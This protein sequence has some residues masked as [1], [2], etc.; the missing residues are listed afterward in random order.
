MGP[1]PNTRTVSPALTSARATSCVATESGSM[2]A[3]SSSASDAGT[4]RSRSTGTF[5]VLA[6]AARQIDAEH[7]E[8]VAKIVGADATRAA[9]AAEKNRLDH[10]A[11]AFGEAG[12]GG[13]LRDV[14]E[15]L[16][17]DDAVLR[18]T[19]IEMPLEDVQV[20]AA[21]AHAPHAEQ[22]FAGR[23]ALASAASRFQRSD[24]RDRTTRACACLLGVAWLFRTSLPGPRSRVVV[25]LTI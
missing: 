6:H 24:Y 20:A 17:T 22:R 12:S 2:S 3:A 5:Q 11:I 15:D 7:L 25:E 1:P 8:V 14:G 23:R 13:R 10:H 19:M 9:G 4:L 18:H 16:M 21:D